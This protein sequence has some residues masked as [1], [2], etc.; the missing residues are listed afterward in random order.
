[1]RVVIARIG[2]GGYRWRA[3]P[4]AIHRDLICIKAEVAASQHRLLRRRFLHLRA[5]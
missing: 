2:A 1:M 3:S 5:P 4:A